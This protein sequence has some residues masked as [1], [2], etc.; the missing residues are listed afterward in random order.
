MR[1]LPLVAAGLAGLLLAGCGG[2]RRA[3]PAPRAIPRPVGATEIGVASWYG[4]PHHGRRAANG[5]VFDMEKLTAAH[6]T[7]PFGTWL[8]VENLTN[9]KTVEVRVN[10]RGP[11]VDGRIVDLAR[12]AAR[13]IDMIGPGTARV[14]LTVIQ[15]PPSAAANFSVQVGAFR[16]RDHAE[17]L[18]RSLEERFG[19]AR[20]VLRAGDPALWRVLVGAE[21]DEIAAAR[22]AERLRGEAGATA[23]FVV[24]LDN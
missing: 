11:F 2:Q 23:A 22:L 12:A 5:E 24:R 16:E 14:R 9:S 10:D 4:H 17:R 3:G 6:R 15:A 20:L 13:S 19:P 7:L 21:P 1:A 8:R 18:R